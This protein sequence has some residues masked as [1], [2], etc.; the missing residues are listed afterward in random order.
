[1]SAL[2]AVDAERIKLT[3]TRSA[4]WSAVGVAVISLGIAVLQATTA[5]DFEPLPPEK[6]ALGVAV[7]GVPVLMVLASMTV[8][9]EYRTGLIRTTFLA[10]PNRTVV[11]LAK[12]VVTAAFSSIFTAAMVLVTVLV[13]RLVAKPMVGSRLSL[14][15][16]DSWR[17]AGSFAVYAMLAAMLGIGVGALVRFTAGAVA[18]LLLWPLVLEPMLA[19]MPST[20]GRVGPF[21]PFG[22]IFRFIEVSWL[23]PTFDTPWGE[24]G[25][26]VYFAV[27]VAGVFVAAV[28]VV[29]SR[30]A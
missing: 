12:A 11:L 19:N 29:N 27:V 8:T 9:G 28:I 17:V 5:Y 26:L 25:S 15:Q 30:D 20:G 23:Y 7:F 14:T 3:T 22:N 13:A 2:A 4:L 1:M 10:T 24:L 18:V 16:P 21:L 6:A